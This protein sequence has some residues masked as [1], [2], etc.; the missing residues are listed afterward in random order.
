M[1]LHVITYTLTCS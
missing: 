1:Y